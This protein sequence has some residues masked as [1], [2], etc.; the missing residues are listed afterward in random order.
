MRKT[1]QQNNGEPVHI[2]KQVLD[3]LQRLA[4]EREV[5]FT[6]LDIAATLKLDDKLSAVRTILSRLHRSGLLI[7]SGVRNKSYIYQPASNFEKKMQWI[8]TRGR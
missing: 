5:R 6:A 8:L 1:S 3:H 2:R 7:K 4:V